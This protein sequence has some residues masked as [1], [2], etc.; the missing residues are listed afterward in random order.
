M[1]PRS[2]KPT[3][4][5]I[6]RS[7]MRCMPAH[8]D[9]V[10]I[11]SQEAAFLGQ[12][13]LA[14]GIIPDDGMVPGP[15]NTMIPIALAIR[16]M[17]E[18]T[19]FAGPIVERT[20]GFAPIQNGIWNGSTE[21]TVTKGEYLAG[22]G[23]PLLLN[24]RI[25]PHGVFHVAG[26][27][28]KSFPVTVNNPNTVLSV[29]IDPTNQQI[30]RPDV[31]AAVQTWYD[32]VTTYPLIGLM[33]QR[34]QVYLNRV[35]TTVN[36]SVTGA[37]RDVH[38]QLANI[39]PAAPPASAVFGPDYSQSYTL[40]GE[41]LEAFIL[42]GRDEAS[43]TSAQRLLTPLRVGYDPVLHLGGGVPQTFP[44]PNPTVSWDVGTFDDAVDRVTVQGIFAGGAGFEG[45]FGRY[46]TNTAL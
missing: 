45:F 6:A 28:L 10:P 38:A 29:T 35:V 26:L 24:S 25:V 18:A 12:L 5:Q 8:V 46:L 34:N 36:L 22:P 7:L 41:E 17:R 43:N 14:E 23:R 27:N 4:D 20:P 42:F 13:S 33:F 2:N 37:A 19:Q 30:T 15:G 44:F 11:N 3:P 21:V 16:T 39:D 32:Q 40:R 9:G 1:A 31:P